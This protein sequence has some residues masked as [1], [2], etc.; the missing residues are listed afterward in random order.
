MQKSKYY[1]MRN[2]LKL[3]VL[4]VAISIATAGCSGCGDKGKPGSNQNPDSP[5]TKIDTSK[6]PI[7]TAKAKIDT[8]KKDTSKK[9]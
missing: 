3:G 2:S 1:A 6:K 5:Q 8:T 9:K 4:V 7:D